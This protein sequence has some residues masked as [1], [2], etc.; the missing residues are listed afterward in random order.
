MGGGKCERALPLLRYYG[1]HRSMRKRCHYGEEVAKSMGLLALEEAL[2]TILTA[3][4]SNFLKC[5]IS[6][7]LF[8]I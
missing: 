1:A 5:S 2:R 8:G 3:K 4:Y 7:A 6:I